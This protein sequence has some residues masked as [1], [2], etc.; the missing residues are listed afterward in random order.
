MNKTQKTLFVVLA[1]I[2][3]LLTLHINGAL[4]AESTKPLK[5]SYKPET[6]GYFQFTLENGSKKGGMFMLVEQT[7]ITVLE[8]K[9]IPTVD[10]D[11]KAMNLTEHRFSV[12]YD[13]PMVFLWCPQHGWEGPASHQIYSQMLPSIA[14]ENFYLPAEAAVECK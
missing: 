8:T 7:T 4:A 5:C 2:G 9:I 13:K 1:I 14:L 6:P 10:E 11:G 12:D 3:V